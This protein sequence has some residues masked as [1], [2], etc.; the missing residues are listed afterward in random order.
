MVFFSFFNN[1][2][3]D[4]NEINKM[5]KFTKQ[6]M[7][8]TIIFFVTKLLLLLIR[9]AVHRKTFFGVVRK[10]STV[11]TSPEMIS[12]YDIIIMRIRKYECELQ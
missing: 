2:L 1:L 11:V 3:K 4:K 9:V 12:L 7:L 8:G 10:I 5:G 6:S